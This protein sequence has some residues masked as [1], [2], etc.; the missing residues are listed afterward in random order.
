MQPLSI[1]EDLLTAS[2]VA[3]AVTLL[4]L[5]GSPRIIE[6]TTQATDAPIGPIEVVLDASGSMRGRLEAVEKMMVAKEFLAVLR[7]QL[8]EDGV[9]P[10]MGLRVYGA[11]SDRRLR[12][13]RD[14]TRLITPVDSLV[15]WDMVLAELQPLGVSPLAT[16]LEQAVDEAAMTYILI[17]DGADNC[18][19]DA[20]TMWRELG[21]RVGASR[22]R[23]HVVALDPGPGDIER[24]RCLSRAGSGS[25][26]QLEKRADVPR[27]A[28]RLALVLR[29]LGL[30]DVRL[31]LGEGAEFSAPVRVLQPLTRELVAAF[32]SGQPAAVPAGMYDVVVETAPP[33]R[34]DRVLVLPGESAVVEE[35]A[36]GTLT[37]DLLDMENQPLRAPLSISKTGDPTEL[38]FASTR[39]SLI[40]GEGFYDIRVDMRDSFA[41][42]EAIAI[43]SRR[44]TRVV[45]GGSGT[46][47]VVAPGSTAPAT[48]ASVFGHGRADSLAIG[49]AH[50]LPA[51]EYRVTVRSVPPYVAEAVVV[52]PDQETTVE[53]PE[54]GVLEVDVFEFDTLARGVEI[55]VIEPT[56]EER[57]GTLTSGERRL[58]RPGTYR[59]EL[60]TIPPR[61]I[62]DITVESF[63][64]TVI[65]QR[66]LSRIEL[67][68]AI[69]EGEADLRLEVLDLSDRTLAI[70]NAPHPAIPRYG[71]APIAQEFG[72]PTNWF[73][74]GR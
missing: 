38:R 23:L 37:V 11:G 24:L 19:R 42:R 43:G 22:P 56:T 62:E 34:A 65:E 57:Y 9:V 71:Q 41:V 52:E 64:V 55:A 31:A 68:G 74:K 69:A 18:G 27:A 5:C 6:A 59:L 48:P 15:G 39:D 47:T 28:R 54:T 60:E 45:L 7:E 61:T 12:D 3:A 21:P 58:A 35:R 49:L 16:A 10:L 14:T 70:M 44:P 50:R 2:R 25:L 17:T 13:C 32:A 8:S 72:E 66:G 26:I 40:L 4:V 30:L 67:I 29:N 36:F 1:P 20:C 63:D 51:G 53:L 33:F 46:L 73:G